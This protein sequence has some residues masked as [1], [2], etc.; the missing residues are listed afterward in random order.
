[1]KSG[2]SKRRTM[3][4]AHLISELQQRLDRTEAVTMANAALLRTVLVHT[5]VGFPAWQPTIAGFR[6]GATYDVRSMDLPGVTAERAP[7]VRAAAE[8]AINDTMAELRAAIQ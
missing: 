5:A 6:E 3:N 7:A 4:Y 2:E 1:M 8:T